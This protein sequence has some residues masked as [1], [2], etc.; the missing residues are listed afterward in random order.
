MKVATKCCKYGKFAEKDLFL[1]EHRRC[2]DEIIDIV[3][4]YY[5]HDLSRDVT[6]LE[7]VNSIISLNKHFN[8]FWSN[9][10]GL[11]PV[12]AVGVYYVSQG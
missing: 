6:N 5:R 3:I 12:D 8:G 4:N 1:S 2:Y 10:Q 7:V 11:A 9:A